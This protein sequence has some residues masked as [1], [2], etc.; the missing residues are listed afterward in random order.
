MGAGRATEPSP[1]RPPLNKRRPDHASARRRRRDCCP[2]CSPPAT[3]ATARRPTRRCVAPGAYPARPDADLPDRR[4]QV[5]GVLRRRR[6]PHEGGRGHRVRGVARRFARGRPVRDGQGVWGWRARVGGGRARDGTSSTLT[7][8]HTHTKYSL[9]FLFPPSLPPPPPP[10]TTNLLLEAGDAALRSGPAAVPG[11][12]AL[13]AVAQ[14]HRATAADLGVPAAAADEVEALL[15]Q[16]TQLLTGVA[17]VQELTPR[18]RDAL[19]SFGERLSTRLFAAYL[20]DRGV[21]AVQADACGEGWVATTDDFGSAD[22][23]YGATLP[24]LAA[25]CAP[26]AHPPGTVLVLTGFLGRG[27]RTGAITTLG[28]GGSDLTA[29]LAGAAL[30][31]PAGRVAEVV[32]WKDVDG[33]LSGD[34]RLVGAD[35][36]R[37]VPALTYDEA[38]ELAFFGAAVLHPL[39]MQPAMLAP[40]G[41]AGLAVRVK[42]SYNTAA[43]GTVIARTRPGRGA[44]GPGGGGGGAPAVPDDALPVS[45]IVLKDNVTLVD[46][47]SPRASGGVGFLAGVFAV[48]RDAGLSVD[49]VAT[50][51]VSVSITLDPARLWERD[52]VEA[53][54]DALRDALLAGSAGAGAGAAGV[55]ITRGVGCVSLI[56]DVGRTA[57]ILERAFRVLGAADIPVLMVSQ[58]ASKTNI[59][60]IVGGAGAGPRAAKA[61]HDEFFGRG[62][63]GA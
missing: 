52:L 45:S 44:A 28:R 25:R 38:A 41:V 14:L 12:P 61:L 15:A 34:P 57:P 59:S 18:A 3:P 8:T 49:V 51:E 39:A 63:G 30:L 58:G 17:I 35:A 2:A 37:P 4:L 32:V 5:W 9:S 24:S 7:H 56:C 20:G 11:L 55:S 26:G 21:P 19:V 62:G 6:G 1:R 40:A 10:Q 53:E 50:S 27:A 48:F 46:A 47:S 13:A 60:L 54:L 16:L 42:N 22:V 36:A 29:V 43:P 31:P 23:D 33:V